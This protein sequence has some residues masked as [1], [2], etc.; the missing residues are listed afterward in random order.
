MTFRTLAKRVKADLYSRCPKV[1]F[2]DFRVHSWKRE[3]YEA[4]LSLS[5]PPLNT[6]LT[7]KEFGKKDRHV[8]LSS[9]DRDPM[10]KVSD[11]IFE[12]F[13]EPRNLS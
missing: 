8:Y 11:I 12:H 13:Q 2:N 6:H 9:D 3:P 1:A 5:P 4:R 10:S 7:L